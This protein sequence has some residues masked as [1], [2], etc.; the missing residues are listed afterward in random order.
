MKIL[1]AAQFSLAQNSFLTQMQEQHCA[2]EGR[3]RKRKEDSSLGH[4][5]ILD[6]GQ[7]FGIIADLQVWRQHLL[8]SER[9]WVQKQVDRLEK[10]TKNLEECVTEAE[11]KIESKRNVPTS[12]IKK[13]MES[14]ECEIQELGRKHTSICSK[15]DDAQI[16]LEQIDKGYGEDLDMQ[17]HDS[18]LVGSDQEILSGDS[19]ID[20][21]DDG[22][23]FS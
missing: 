8:I 2:E 10:K 17:S 4:K 15:L 11:R 3:K 9:K 20:N 19:D 5:Q 21:D 6:H 22:V 7:A 16:Q 12:C 18:G 23:F 1:H 13:S 14:W